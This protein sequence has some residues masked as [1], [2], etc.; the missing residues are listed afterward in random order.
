MTLDATD[1]EVSYGAVSALKGVS[2]RIGDGEAVALIGSNG[3]G[4]STALKTLS[5]MLAPRAGVVLHDGTDIAGAATHVIARRGIAHVPEG[6]RLFPR[7]SVREN[8]RLGAFHRKDRQVN[9][10]LDA[11]LD[12][13]PRLRER[14]DQEAGTLSG[15]EQQMVAISRALM[16]RP[17]LL[18][19]DEPSL[20]LSPLMVQTVFEAVAAIHAAGTALLLVEQ[21]AGQALAV[22]TRGYVMR[23]GEIVKE[24]D[25]QALA[26]DPMVREIY[27]GASPSAPEPAV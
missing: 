7:M 10:D 8:L 16:S 1:L 17:S 3:A 14:L 20:G 25:S 6:R 13:F 4:K 24:G 26:T 21:N 12:L 23:S 22:T 2:L 27:L 11:Q 18:L 9:D 15:G 19:L 5:G